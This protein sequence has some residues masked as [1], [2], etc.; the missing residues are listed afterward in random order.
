[1]TFHSAIVTGKSSLTGSFVA[2]AASCFGF[3]FG[4]GFASC[5]DICAPSPQAAADIRVTRRAPGSKL[6]I[7]RRHGA[8]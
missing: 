6:R 8:A 7:F 4:F 1:M 5:F 3:G 2:A